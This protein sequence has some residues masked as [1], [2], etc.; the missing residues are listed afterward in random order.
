MGN[1]ALFSPAVKPAVL[2]SEEPRRAGGSGRWSAAWRARSSS[3]PAALLQPV[4][5]GRPGTAKVMCKLFALCLGAVFVGSI[6]VVAR[7][8]DVVERGAGSTHQP[9]AVAYSFGIFA[10]LLLGAGCT[11]LW[12][13]L[14]GGLRECDVLQLLREEAGPANKWCDDCAFWQ[15]V[16]GVASSLRSSSSPAAPSTTGSSLWRWVVAE[17]GA[18][19]TVGYCGSV[20]QVIRVVLGRG[21]RWFHRAWRSALGCGGKRCGQHPPASGGRL[22]RD[23]RGPALGRGAYGLVERFRLVPVSSRMC[24]SAASG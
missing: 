17:S 16:G 1:S 5:P 19:G 23:L 12:H 10:G 20:A 9:Q 22:L 7:H 15:A 11:G 21:L 24:C 4:H 14:G 6:V 18:S 13:V 3:S 2:L 8:W